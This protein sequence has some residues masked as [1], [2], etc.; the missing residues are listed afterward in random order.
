MNDIHLYL[1]YNYSNKVV[2]QDICHSLVLYYEHYLGTHFSM[3]ADAK[4]GFRQSVYEFAEPEVDTIHEIPL[5]LEVLAD[6]RLV[7][8][9]Q[10]IPLVISIDRATATKDF[11]FRAQ[12]F[13]F[14]PLERTKQVLFTILSDDIRENL[15]GFTL[16]KETEVANGTNATTTIVITDTSS[17]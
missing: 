6:H 16:Y 9:V 1:D 8:T 4:V 7:V 5:I 2:I 17:E 3:H 12:T 11:T 14:Q 10:M 15:E 13:T